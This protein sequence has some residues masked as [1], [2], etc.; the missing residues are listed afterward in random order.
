MIQAPD[1]GGSGARLFDLSV[2]PE[3]RDDLS[4]ADRAAALLGRLEAELRR[5]AP[6]EELAEAAQIRGD[7]DA[8]L[9]AMGYAGDD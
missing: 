8:E 4:Q 5:Y 6:I 2:D 1:R 3:E 7:L 9:Q